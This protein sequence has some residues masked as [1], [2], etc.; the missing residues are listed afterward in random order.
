MLDD[1]TVRAN[2]TAQ[3]RE[4]EALS[5]GSAEAR[6][7]VALDQQSVGRLSRMDALQGQAMANAAERRRTTE[8]ARIDA[9]LRR[10]DDGT[11]GECLRCGEEIA[12]KRLE[13]DPAATLCVACARNA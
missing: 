12:E 2:L 6:K 13:I 5:A 4:L 3:R 1:D 9:A 7:P 8:I 10:L 11:Y